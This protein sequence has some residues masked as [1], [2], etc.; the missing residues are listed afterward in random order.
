MF[1]CCYHFSTR[2][3]FV[4][5]EACRE[6]R[7]PP[8]AASFPWPHWAGRLLRGS[9]RL[10]VFDGVT[11]ELTGPFRTC[12]LPQ[13]H[14]VGVGN[15]YRSLVQSWVADVAVLL[16]YSGIIRLW[17]ID[18]CSHQ[19]HSIQTQL[20]VYTEAGSPLSGMLGPPAIGTWETQ[21]VTRR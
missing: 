15:G 18:S 12:F 5:S 19:T 3:G 11:A 13:L 7:A 2:L 17:G 14:Q 8:S 1:T 21:V 6:G 4:V 20:A 16:L 10:A 9:H